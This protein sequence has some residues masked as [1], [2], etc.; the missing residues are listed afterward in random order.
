MAAT[1]THLVQTKFLTVFNPPN[2]SEI[3]L[4]V[5]F[6]KLRPLHRTACRVAKD[7]VDKLRPVLSPGVVPEVKR[8]YA[9]AI[10]VH[11]KNLATTPAENAV[12]NWQTLL[13]DEVFEK[14]GKRPTS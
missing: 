14:A 8:H 7:W 3:H 6:G 13:L 2:S 1:K 5:S 12:K 10:V 11:L 9:R 4:K